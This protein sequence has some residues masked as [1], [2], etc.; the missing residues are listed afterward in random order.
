MADPLM[1]VKPPSYIMEDAS[2]PTF[3][4]NKNGF[5]VVR[6]AIDSFNYWR[7][8]KEWIYAIFHFV[9]VV[10]IPGFDVRG[11]HQASSAPTLR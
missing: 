5:T 1:H 6:V 4:G 3:A 2:D 8:D 10:A 9:L 11:S 7:T